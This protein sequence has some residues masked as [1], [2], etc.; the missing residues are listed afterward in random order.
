VRAVEVVSQF[1]E[2]ASARIAVTGKS[3]GG[4]L[5]LAVA[6]L[7]PAVKLCLPD[8]PFLCHFRRA[9]RIIDSA[10]YYEICSFLPFPSG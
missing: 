9:T 7:E 1:S 4:G 10:P 6:G 8:V 5:S 2:I 3:Q